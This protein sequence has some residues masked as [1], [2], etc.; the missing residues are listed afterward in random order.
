[1]PKSFKGVM[2]EYGA[3]ELHSGG[4]GK[5]VKALKQAEAIAFS[6]QRQAGHPHRLAGSH[7]G[8]YVTEHHRGAKTRRK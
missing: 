6:E 1:M 3:G 5:V 2:K 4:S 7:D 8:L